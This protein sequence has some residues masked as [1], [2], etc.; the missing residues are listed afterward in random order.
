MQ[1]HI[2]S[3]PKAC[4]KMYYGP[5]KPRLIFLAINSKKYV[6]WKKA[7]CQFV[8][9]SDSVLRLWNSHHIKALMLIKVSLFD[10]LYAQSSVFQTAYTNQ[11]V[12]TYFNKLFFILTNW[13]V[14]YCVKMSEHCLNVSNNIINQ[15]YFLN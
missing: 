3:V 11:S 12:L 8:S 2:S 4:G 15:L 6:W 14:S 1:K 9:V 10:W 13:C 5:M 7:K